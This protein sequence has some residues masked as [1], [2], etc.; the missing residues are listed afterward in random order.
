MKKFMLLITSMILVAAIAACGTENNTPNTTGTNPDSSDAEPKEQAVEDLFTSSIQINQDGG[1]IGVIYEFKNISTEP[2]ALSY[3]NALRA[4]YILLNEAGEKVAQ[5]SEQVMV[6]MAVENQTL[7]PNESILTDFMLE[8][9]PN[10][11]YTIEV[12]STSYEYNAKIV[13][14]L[15][16]TDSIYEIGTGIYNGQADPH[17]IEIQ[18]DDS[19]QAFQLSDAAKEQLSEIEEADEIKFLYTKSDIEQMTI[20][21]FYFDN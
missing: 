12:F 1:S 14:S 17:T 5:H 6:T 16:V 9:I 2:Q 13:Q 7:Q 11:S 15:E 21:K 4:D 20:E 18:V 3:P 10:G 19:P 8:Q